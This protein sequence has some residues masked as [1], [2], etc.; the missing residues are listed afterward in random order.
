MSE[1]VVR[2]EGVLNVM[3]VR[4]QQFLHVVTEKVDEHHE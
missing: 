4:I 1:A 3:H 2:Q